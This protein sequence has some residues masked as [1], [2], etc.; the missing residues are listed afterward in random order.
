MPEEDDVPEFNE[1]HHLASKY[2][3]NMHLF[4]YKAVNL[5]KITFNKFFSVESRTL[6]QSTCLS[7]E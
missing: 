5:I 6:Q 2:I 7:E 1:C 3:N 4:F